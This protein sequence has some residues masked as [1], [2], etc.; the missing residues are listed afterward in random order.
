MN[1]HQRLAW[2]N[3]AVAGGALI[4]VLACWPWIHEKSIGGFGFLGLLGLGVLFFVPRRK[5]VISDERD[6][7]IQMRA[8]HFAFA[9]TWV[10]QFLFFNI[11]CRTASTD[12]HPNMVP[13]LIV[14]VGL[15]GQWVMYILL[16]SIATLV[17]YSRGA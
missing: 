5:G 8:S 13:I 9:L 12:E 15:W 4:V 17:Q 2:F 10:A 16:N 7:L 3:L 11:I 14:Q 6:R 1:M